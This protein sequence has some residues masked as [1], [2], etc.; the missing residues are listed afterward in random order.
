MALMFQDFGVRRPKDLV[1][2]YG[3]APYREG[4]VFLGSAGYALLT[5]HRELHPLVNADLAGL[6]NLTDGSTLWQ[7]RLTVSVSNNSDLS[8][9][10]W[11][12]TG[13]KP[14]LSGFTVVTRSEFGMIPDGGGMYARWF[15]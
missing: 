6:A 13:G 15:F 1:T 2:V 12:G 3:D 5:L 11:I 14:R 7:P 8:V 9:Y 4:W 10:G